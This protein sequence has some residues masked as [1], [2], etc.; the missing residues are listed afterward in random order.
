MVFSDFKCKDCGKVFEIAR[1]YNENFPEHPVCPTCNSINTIRKYSIGAVDV[2]EGRY[3]NAS[4]GYSK[5]IVYHPS[6][7]GKF[8]GKR[9]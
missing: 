9:S 3:G 8:K 2:A 1:G 6:K 5:G 4:T 7:F